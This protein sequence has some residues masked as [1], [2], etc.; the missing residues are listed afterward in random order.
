MYSC[1][2]SW[3]KDYRLGLLELVDKANPLDSASWSKT[4]PVFHGNEKV[5]GVGH[6]SFAKS[7]D[8][9]QDWIIYHSKI[10]EEP[11]WPRDV[12]IQPFT[13]TDE[14]YPDFGEPV[15]VEVEMPVPSGE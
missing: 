7:P 5:L 3:L 11:G 10:T 8:G 9:S 15:N 13:W 1:R 6:C 2:E 14:G 4:G 12:R